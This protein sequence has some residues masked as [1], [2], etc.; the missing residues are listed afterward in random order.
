VKYEFYKPFL[1]V[2]WLSAIPPALIVFFRGIKDFSRQINNGGDR[3]A[4]KIIIELEEREER[5]R[6][7]F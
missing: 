1:W 4:R 3:L 6:S 5:E 2:R 7:S